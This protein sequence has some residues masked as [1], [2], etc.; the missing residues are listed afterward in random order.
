MS[1]VRK[2]VP[3]EIIEKRENGGII[4]ISTSSFDRA[5]DR[6]FAAGAATENYLANPVVQYGHI[7]DAPW[8]TVGR[9]V[10]LTVGDSWIDAEFELRPAANEHD[11]QNIVL[12]LWNGGWVRTASI[13]FR[14]MNAAKNGAG[15]YDYTSWELLEWSLVPVPMNQEALRLAMK[16][17]QAEVPATEIKGLSLDRIVELVYQ[18]I[19]REVWRD[20]TVYI[21]LEVKAIYSDH[22][23]VDVEHVAY[24]VRYYV[25]GDS[26][27]VDPRSVWE[28]GELVFVPSSAVLRHLAATVRAGARHSKADNVAIQRIHDDAVALGATCDDT[29]TGDVSDSVEAAAEAESTTK[30]TEAL[31]G[32]KA[33]LLR[34]D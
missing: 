27:I 30:L 1:I 3:F 9:T 33:I 20:E 29:T 13:G 8:S 14:P 26:V 15:G 28:A 16:A 2:S 23:L 17:V 31:R 22:A 34:E 32:L 11:P 19:Y 5:N 4:R 24:R 18:A 6:V 7:Y 10:S 25:D 12:L 21:E